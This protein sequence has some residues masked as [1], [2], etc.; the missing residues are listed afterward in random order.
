MVGTRIG[1]YSIVRELGAGGMGTVYEALHVQ[2]GRRVALKVLKAEVASSPEMLTRFFNEARAV[3]HVEHP[4]LVQISDFGSLPDGSPY[5]VMELLRG[6]T[7]AARLLARGR[8]TEPEAL[9]I[10]GQ[11]ASILAAAHDKG[12][13]H[14]D[15]K[16]SNVMLVPDPAVTGGERVKLLDFGVAKIVNSAL[17]SG[18]PMTQTGLP[19]GTPLYMSPEQCTGE[20][21]IDGKADVY[22]LGIILYELLA[23]QRPFEAENPLALLNMHVRKPPPP[24]PPLVPAVTSATV[25]LLNSLLS[26]E[27]RARP[28]A[29]Q[30]QRTCQAANATTLPLPRA[31]ALASRQQTWW[32]AMAGMALLLL[33]LLTW[34]LLH[35]RRSALP[36]QQHEHLNSSTSRVMESAKPL[37]SGQALDLGAPATAAGTAIAAPNSQASPSAAGSPSKHA[38]SAS[39]T[40]ASPGPAR[41]QDHLPRPAV[42]STPAAKAKK[43]NYE[44]PPF[45]AN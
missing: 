28:T 33:P 22:A 45:I 34:W 44:K 32:V 14:R 41:V 18:L 13:V 37:T 9:P 17:G 3:N 21:E 16:P 39:P 10:V 24:L 35:T 5:L 19:M 20:T 8:L 12:I 23:G 26:K 15:V 36:R 6:E 25:Q 1:A 40:A 4:G 2:L 30:V 31:T 29:A 43:P 11:L 27:S 42:P 38:A 7:L